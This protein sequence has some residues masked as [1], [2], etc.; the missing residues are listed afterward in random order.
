MGRVWLARDEVLHRDVAVKEVVPPSGLTESEGE[1]ASERGLREARAIARLNHP[2]VV[3]IFDVV[4][5]PQRPWIV[6]E[7]VRSRSLQE[8]IVQDG[9]LPAA[10]VA[11]IGL[12][13]LS[14]LV[15]AHK[16]GV[17]HRDVKPSNVLIA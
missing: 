3:R 13:I 17:L 4:A 16:A 10:E 1:E 14:A 7:Y 8:R 2:N 9:P 6:M 15:A 12:G 11:R 5:K